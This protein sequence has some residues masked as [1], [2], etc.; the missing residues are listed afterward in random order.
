MDSDASALVED[1]RNLL[2]DDSGQYDREKLRKTIR[3]LSIA[4]E[5]PGDTVY[6]ISFLPF[7]TTVCRIAV[8]LNLF[9]ILV[10][11]RAPRSSEGLAEQVH[12]DKDL[13]VR[14]LRHLAANGVIEEAGEDLWTANNITNTLA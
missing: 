12:A 14:L 10:E 7:V 4:L 9:N 3:K 8:K 1:L 11:S 6:R 13:L 2:R 5:T